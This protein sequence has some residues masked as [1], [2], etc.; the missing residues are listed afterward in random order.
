MPETFLPVRKALRLALATCEWSN[1]PISTLRAAIDEE[2]ERV[3]PQP[4]L[5]LLESVAA[6]TDKDHGALVKHEALAKVAGAAYPS[7]LASISLHR[8][9]LCIAG[10]VSHMHAAIKEGALDD[11]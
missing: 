8:V 10:A 2:M 5:S 3:D 7:A 4:L 9:G 11:A 1:T 6:R